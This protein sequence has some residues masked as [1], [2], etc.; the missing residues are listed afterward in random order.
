MARRAKVRGDERRLA[1]P[2]SEHATM[3]HSGDNTSHTRCGGEARPVPAE[4]L[5]AGALLC[6]GE[7]RQHEHRARLRGEALGGRGRAGRDGAGAL[8]VGGVPRWQHV[9]CHGLGHGRHQHL[10]VGGQRQ[11]ARRRAR[12]AGRRRAEPDLE[13]HLG[14]GGLRG[15]RGDR[16][17]GGGLRRRVQAE[18]AAGRAVHGQLRRAQDAVVRRGGARRNETL[19]LLPMPPQS[20]AATAP[21]P[22]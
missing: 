21:A 10:R 19:L 2:R 4:R 3:P 14:A 13:L 7:R 15:E 12:R 5:E 8:R 22:I 16:G 17:K 1:I 18:P 9:E 11:R 6:G 20:C